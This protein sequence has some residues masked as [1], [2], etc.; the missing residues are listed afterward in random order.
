MGI[1][2][3][4]VDGDGRFD[5]LVT[6]FDTEMNALYLTR[7]GEAFEESAASTGLGLPSL[8]YTSWGTAFY[9]VDH[10][11]D[12]DL[13][14]VNGSVEPPIVTGR[15]E[16]PGGLGHANPKGEPAGSQWRPAAS[17]TGWE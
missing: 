8:P 3:G 5:L 1:A 2:I 12:L 17:A 7:S 11:G 9:D 15:I 16:P 6:H 4:D 13:A 14:V 10:D